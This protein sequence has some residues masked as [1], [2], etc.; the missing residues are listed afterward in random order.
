M[1]NKLYSDTN[2]FSDREKAKHREGLDEKSS[3]SIF[4]QS[5][6]GWSKIER[7][8]PNSVTDEYVFY[9]KLQYL[10]CL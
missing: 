6:L 5:K 3:I 10:K 4:D 9:S 7:N 1:S 2:T 8:K